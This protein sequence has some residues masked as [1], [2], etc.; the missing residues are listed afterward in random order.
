MTFAALDQF[1]ST[2]ANVIAH[3]AAIATGTQVCLHMPSLH[4]KPPHIGST[5]CA[6]DAR[7]V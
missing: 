4:A 6:L 7:F 2:D 5:P 1:L 3:K